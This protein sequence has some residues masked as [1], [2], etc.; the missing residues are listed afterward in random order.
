M[1]SLIFQAVP[2]REED[3]P[4][5]AAAEQEQKQRARLTALVRFVGRE[6]FVA[7][8]QTIEE[9]DANSDQ[10]VSREE[11]NADWKEI[12]FRILDRRQRFRPYRPRHR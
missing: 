1:G 10:K 3:L 5:L 4:R 8:L 12:A 6:Q 7:A 2:A 9:T 11:R